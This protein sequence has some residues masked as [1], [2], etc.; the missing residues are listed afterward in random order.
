MKELY[1]MKENRLFSTE[2][3]FTLIEL[4][5][6]VA[7]IAILAAIAVPNFLEAQVRSKISRA[8]ADIRTIDIALETY[9]IDNN[10][11]PNMDPILHT[12][13]NYGSSKLKN[14][15][16]TLTTPLAYLSS[17]PKDVFNPGWD[18][19]ST[20]DNDVITYGVSD[21]KSYP[22][23]LLDSY[24]QAEGYPGHPKWVLF[25]YGPLMNPFGWIPRTT[26]VKPGGIN[27]LGTI[28]DAT[29]GTVTPGLIARVGP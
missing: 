22:Q 9:T 25:S 28:Y 12:I 18:I 27:Y 17:I 6:V 7:I 13:I 1:E 26:T 20:G 14:R 3:A 19:Y 8:R 23:T 21:A 5:I 16:I 10:H 4:L 29:N 24:G 11:Y 2:R 15:L